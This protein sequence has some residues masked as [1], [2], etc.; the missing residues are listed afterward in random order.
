MKTVVHAARPVTPNPSL[1][2]FTPRGVQLTVAGLVL[3]VLV[4]LGFW[5]RR[6]GPAE[7]KPTATQDLQT[8]AQQEAQEG[9]VELP[10]A[11]I[12]SAGLHAT[13]V[14]RRVMQPAR[15]VPGRIGYDQNRHLEITSPVQGIV[16]QVA[17]KRGQQVQKGDT[18]AV[19]SSSEIGQA[20][21]EVLR[22]QAEV[23]LATREFKWADEVAGNVTLLLESLKSRQAISEVEDYFQGRVL[24]EH[25]DHLLSAYSKL[26]LAESVVGRTDTLGTQGVISGRIAEQRTS[27]RQVAAAAFQAEYEQSV[28]ECAR[29]RDRTKAA[30]DEAT[31]LLQVSREH[32]KALRGPF[33]ESPEITQD[34][35]LSELILEAPF[36]GAIQQRS[37]VV[38]SRLESGDPVFVLADTN[39]LWLSA[40]LREADWQALDLVDGQQIAFHVPAI[41]DQVFEAKMLFVGGEVSAETRALPVVAEIDNSQKSLKPGMFA[42]VSLPVG[43]ETETWAVSP[44]A[45][46]RH[47]GHAFV[48]VVERPGVY[49]Q[50]HVETGL[51]TSDWVA[52]Q[53][54]LKDGQQVVDRGAFYLKSELLLEGEEE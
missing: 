39:T 6:N 7:A 31:R 46:M 35:R 1:G 22:R 36:D 20:R 49:R 8:R 50:Q 9:I 29:T 12:E 5:W 4:V 41:P 25:R 15:Q 14:Q 30:L 43:E 40:E 52:I 51:E 23:R 13:E 45:I 32:F 10:V 53:S 2:K 18:L 44:G 24:G 19:V 54:G 34:D 27:E 37:V 38:G 3:V 11:K 28:L 47:E 48:F 21:N 26:L 16:T 17:V 42:W 33:S